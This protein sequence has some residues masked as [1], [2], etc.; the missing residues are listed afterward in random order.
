M[1]VIFPHIKLID[2]GY[3]VDI[4]P[5]RKDDKKVPVNV[6]NREYSREKTEKLVKVLKKDPNVKSI[7]FN[8]KMIH[9]VKEVAGHN[10]HLHVD[11]KE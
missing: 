7:L 8:D 1:E 2:L 10:D 6:N 5:L 9:G 3:Q 11:F 4:R